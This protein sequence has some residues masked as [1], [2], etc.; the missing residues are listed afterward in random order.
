MDLVL[1]PFFKSLS[2]SAEDFFD[3]FCHVALRRAHIS[4]NSGLLMDNVSA[5]RQL[6]V[7]L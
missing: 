7:N 4:Y 6:T 1:L 3:I 2:P 5:H